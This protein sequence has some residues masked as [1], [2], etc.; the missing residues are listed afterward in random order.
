MT[1]TLASEL[2]RLFDALNYAIYLLHIILE[3]T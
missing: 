1:S 2:V 3:L